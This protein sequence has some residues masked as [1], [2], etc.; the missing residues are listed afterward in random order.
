MY[1]AIW[2][3]WCFGQ[4]YQVLNTAQILA[5]VIFGSVSLMRENLREL[6]EN[7]KHKIRPPEKESVPLGQLILAVKM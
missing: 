2:Q 5:L 7:L 6:R 1:L 3:N 4:V